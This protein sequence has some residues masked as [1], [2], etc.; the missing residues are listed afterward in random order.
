[1]QKVVL[2]AILAV[3]LA[4]PLTAARTP[5]HGLALRRVIWWM[6]A[7]IIVYAAG[8]MFVYPHMVQ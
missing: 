1:M 4:V 8:V 5:G 2:I 6:V 3:T 7:G